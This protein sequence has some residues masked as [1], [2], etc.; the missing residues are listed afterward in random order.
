M[1]YILLL[2]VFML[3]CNGHHRGVKSWEAPP[4]RELHTAK[5]FISEFLGP[6]CWMH[7][8]FDNNES[9]DVHVP[10]T[11]CQRQGVVK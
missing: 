4:A 2:L 7:V 5:V 10:L 1:R 3:G 8:K 6:A 9:L 11:V